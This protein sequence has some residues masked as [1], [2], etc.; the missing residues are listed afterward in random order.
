MWLVRWNVHRFLAFSLDWAAA[1][2]G[3]GARGPFIATEI[4]GRP[5]RHTSQPYHPCMRP[6]QV[7]DLKSCFAHPRR[8]VETAVGPME[9][10]D[11]GEGEPLLAVHGTLGGWDQGLV[12]TEYIRAN[13][14]RIISPSRPGYLGTPLSTGRT[15][16]AQAEAL[17]ALMDA[18]GIGRFA[19]FG[20]SAGGPAAYALASRIPQ[21]VR[22]LLQVDSVS[23][24][25]PAPPLARLS[26]MDPVIRFQIWLVHHATRPLLR[27]LFRRFG[28]ASK[29]EAA[30]RAAAIAADP[31]RVAHLEA[32]LKAS[33]GWARRR[34]G[35]DAD[36]AALTGLAPLD[37]EKITCPTL[38]MHGTA[39]TVV[40]P[41]NAR[42]AHARIPGSELYWMRGSHVSFFLEAAD[43]AQPYALEWLLRQ[44][45]TG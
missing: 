5:D 4:Q 31:V 43:T 42:H 11:R 13:G 44:T 15:P 2:T 7:E 29:E 1:I 25:T 16:A 21:R 41:D 18:L 20:G 28:E 40:P 14:F 26:A 39:D 30:E 45:E 27:I 37:L 9:Y 34:A 22:V 23:L 17:A 35:F 38:I 32:I 36:A 3:G 33:S 10:A 8:T 6:L 19:V 24:P 12:A